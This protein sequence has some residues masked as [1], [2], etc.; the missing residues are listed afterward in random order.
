MKNL[1]A[2]AVEM[3]GHAHGDTVTAVIDAIRRPVTIVRTWHERARTR[4]HLLAL[5]DYLLDDV[6]LSRTDLNKPFWRA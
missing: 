5:D 1:N 3:Y 2:H 6:G 4:R